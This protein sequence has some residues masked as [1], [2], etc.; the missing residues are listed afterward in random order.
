MVKLLSEKLDEID[1][2]ILEILKRDARMPFTDI[3]R[4]LAI[5]DATVHIRVKRMMDEGI[6]KKYTVEV[7]EVAFGRRISGFVLMNVKSGAL[8]EVS[9]QLAENERISG[10]YEVHGPN[11]LIM[12]IG[13]SDLDEMRDLILEI[14]KI[15]NVVKS[16]L[17]PV[18][19]IWKG[20]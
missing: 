6:I 13:A 2:R 15:P 4:E 1:R 7:D 3:G 5:S 16:E 11:D 8:E 10:V 14:R 18:F 9:K 12:K 20:N 17:I 19:K